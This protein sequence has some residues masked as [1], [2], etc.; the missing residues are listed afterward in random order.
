VPN[1]DLLFPYMFFARRSGGAAPYSLIASG[2]PPADARLFGAELP[3]LDFAGKD[4][5]P[6]LEERLARHVGVDREQ[7]IVTVGASAAMLI[8]G[9]ALFRGARVAVESPCYQPLAALPELCGGG[10]RPFPRSPAE[11]HAVDPERV[12]RALA[13]GSGPG[14]VLLSTPHNPSGARCAPDELL[15]VAEIA[16]AQGGFLISNEVYLEFVPPA[17]RRSAV[18][19]APSAIA[20]GSLTKAYG[21]GA[22]RIGWIVLGERARPLRPRFEDASYLATVDL[23]TPVLRLGARA[24]EQ[25]DALRAPYER[26]RAEGRPLLARWLAETPGVESSVPEHGLIAFPRLRGIEDTHAFQRRAVREH[27]VDV[28]PGEYFG[29]PG[30][31]RVGYGVEPAVLGEALARLTRAIAAARG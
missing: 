7:V 4:A 23:P 12:R 3:D 10:L 24:L 15:A 18:H 27:G 11:G 31:V 22:L 6:R 25:I 13:D 16:A 19:L 17:E 9:L 14:H 8:T 20:I 30:H 29:A 28:V 21:L 5:L 1:A 2:M 26:L